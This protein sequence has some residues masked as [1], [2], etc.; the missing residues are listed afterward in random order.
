MKENID[1]QAILGRSNYRAFFGRFKMLT[2]IQKEAIPVVLQGHS[3]LVTAGTASGKT[4]AAIAPLIS[5]YFSNDKDQICRILIVSPTKSLVNDLF[6]RLSEMTAEIGLDIARKTGDFSLGS[7]TNKGFPHILITTPE[8]L[9]SLIQQNAE[10]I[11]NLRV[12]VIDEIHVLAGTPR[13]DQLRLVIRRLERIIAASDGISLVSNGNLQSILQKVALSATVADPFGI[14][15]TFLGCDS[16]VV[17]VGKIRK[18]DAQVVFLSESLTT[19]GRQIIDHCKNSLLSKKILFFMNS[20]KGVDS[21]SEALGVYARKYG[22]QVFSHHA[23]LSSRRRHETETFFAEARSA[24]CV[25]T[26]SMGVGIDIGSVDLVTCIDMPHSLEELVQRIGRSGRRGR[27]SAAIFVVKSKA[28]A[29]LLRAY[30]SWARRG[31]LPATIPVPFK[32]SVLV[33][34]ILAVLKHSST[35]ETTS[36]QLSNIFVCSVKPVITVEMLRY[37][38]NSMIE[39]DYLRKKGTVLQPGKSGYEFMSN[40]KLAFSNIDNARVGNSVIDVKTGEVIANIK[41]NHDVGKVI[42][43][44]GRRLRVLPGSKGKNIYTNPLNRLDVKECDDSVSYD[45]NPSP[46][47]TL[48]DG[49]ILREFLGIDRSEI[50][51]YPASESSATILWTWLGELFNSVLIEILQRNGQLVKARGSFAI[52]FSGVEPAGAVNL[53]RKALSPE[54]IELAAEKLRIERWIP[55]GPNS[56]ILGE[57]YLRFCRKMAVNRSAL[58]SAF[59][60]AVLRVIETK[61]EVYYQLEE[62]AKL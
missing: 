49:T 6:K 55:L 19:L 46:P 14:A 31:E 52:Q 11:L 60:G 21:M 17:K 26:S 30:L 16:K 3:V 27:A 59:E 45:T 43:L 18:I 62:L 7:V 5:R 40:S 38:I 28:E 41:S 1:F 9:D 58:L 47:F 34:Q 39:H 32:I 10:I 48:D 15:Q 51:A 50:A 33:Q 54:S 13:G 4:E 2:D 53:I 8:G 44:A 42:P 22:Y 24:I 20:R 56:R 29:I 57:D 37:T 12:I 23:S 25:A 36:E 61:T 35:R